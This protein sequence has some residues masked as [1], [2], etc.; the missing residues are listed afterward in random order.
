MG[1]YHS[2][3]FA[4][5]LRIPT[6]AHLW[7]ETDRIDRV[8]ATIKDRC[9]N[10][11][12]LT[13]GAYDDDMLFLVAECNAVSL[14]EYGRA[15]SATAEQRASWDHQLAHAVHHLGYGSIS[16]LEAPGWLCVPDLA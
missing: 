7:D 16:G 14:G 5:G 12:H 8:L 3:Y 4:Y 10:V 2:S 11:G 13:A 1:Y 15:A 9:P 6:D